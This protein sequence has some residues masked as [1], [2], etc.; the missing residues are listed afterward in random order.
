MFV[1]WLKKRTGDKFKARM[2]DSLN[3][4]VEVSIHWVIIGVINS[5][6]RSDLDDEALKEIHSLINKNKDNVSLW[7]VEHK[8]KFLELVA[9]KLILVCTETGN[10]YPTP[11]N[12][13]E[14][15]ETNTQDIVSDILAED[16][17]SERFSVLV[18]MLYR[19]KMHI[20]EISNRSVNIELKGF[21]N[22]S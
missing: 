20:D 7:S 6:R 19:V 2:I 8:R 12:Y 16:I 17:D 4:S 1:A 15:C 5:I 10:E 21:R 22:K 13:M 14:Y 3:R 9:D 11:Q 18:D